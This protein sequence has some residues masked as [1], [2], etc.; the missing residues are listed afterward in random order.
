V[1]DGRHRRGGGLLFGYDMGIISGALLSI[2]DAFGALAGGP[3][4][5]NIGRRR[6]VLVAAVIFVAGS[7][8]SALSTGTIFLDGARFV[9]G[10]AVGAAG[11]IMPVYT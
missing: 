9:L 1:R 11:M 4:S 2:K 5:N 10:T 7:I 6:T 3:I 8:A